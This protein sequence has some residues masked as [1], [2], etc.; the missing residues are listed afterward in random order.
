LLR[1]PLAV[2]ARAVC[3]PQL[4]IASDQRAVV[5]RVD[6]NNTG[7]VKCWPFR[8]PYTARIKKSGPEGR[9][10]IQM[11]KG[12]TPKP[13][14]TG[15]VAPVVGASRTAARSAR[16]TRRRGVGSPAR[17]RLF[18]ARCRLVSPLFH[19]ASA[20]CDGGTTIAA[21]STASGL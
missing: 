20:R 3:A 10:T 7:M 15:F 5:L 21:R 18:V 2:A 17:H 19:A 13:L 12:G 16:V 9:W 1:V 11:K 8:H 6:I 14:L 4:V